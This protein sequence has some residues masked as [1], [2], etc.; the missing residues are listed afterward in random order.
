MF[1]S[2]SASGHLMKKVRYIIFLKDVLYLSLF[3]FGGPQ[4]HLALFFRVL[5]QKRKYLTEEELTELNSFCNILPGPASTQTL[6]AVGFKIGGPSLAFLSLLVWILPATLIMIV[7]AICVE[8]LKGSLD[9]T[10]F[11]RPMAISFVAYAAIKVFK[12]SVTTKT[13]FALFLISAIASYL[14]NY[15]GIFPLVLIFSGFVTAFR[16]KRHTLEEKVEKWRI[17]WDNFIL[18]VFIFLGAALLGHFLNYKPIKLFENFFRN[19]SYIFGGG[20]PLSGLL[21]KEFV[22]FKHYLSDEEF[23]AGFAVLQILP[24]PLFS[25]SAF[26][27]S[28]SMREFGLTGQ[29]VGGFIAS[30]GIF[31]PGTLMIFFMLRFW[32][33]LKKYRPVKA[34]LGGINAAGG[35]IILATVVLLLQ[36]ILLNGL[37]NE[38]VSILIFAGTLVVL[39]FT[40]VPPPFL[41]LFG[42]LAGILIH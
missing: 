26:I 4:V 25:F 6:T 34:S 31:L 15:P 23:A 11:I 42:L 16:F 14:I 13:G 40:S 8:Y 29:I 41:I 38:L 33:Q 35:G 2:R 22:E 20:Q 7:T 5:V 19:G 39:L 3:S 24:G 37:E 30:A 36:P 32:E 1:I 27:G 18:Y 21:H 28:L 17:E 10:R 9:V 12:V